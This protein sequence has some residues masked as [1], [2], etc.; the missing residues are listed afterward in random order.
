ML[1]ADSMVMP[2]ARWSRQVESYFR[3]PAA[4]SRD[5]YGEALARI[6]KEH[7]V[8]CVIPTCEEVF[9]LSMCKHLLPQECMVFAEDISKLRELH[10]KYLFQASATGCGIGLPRTML[11][12]SR[13]LLADSWERDMVDCDVVYKRC[14]SR[15]AEGT[16][17]KPRL[18]QVDRLKPSES[19]PWVAQEFIPGEEVC[20]YAVAVDGR[21]T[22][23]ATYKPLHRAGKGAGICFE[24]VASSEIDAF[25]TRFVEKHACSG[26]ISFDFIVSPDRGTFVIECNPRATSGVHL[27][28]RDTD[29]NGIFEG[30]LDSIVRPG[31]G[32]AMV[33]LA[34]VAYGLFS[35]D[36]SMLTDFVSSRDVV[37]KYDDPL[38]VIG[39]MFATGETLFRAARKGI[40]PI[41]A[42]TADIEW[43]GP[44]A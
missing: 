11:I 41:A 43:N 22:A 16:L 19:D 4:N 31:E 32:K 20:C 7:G 3:L 44:L 38:P 29:W 17:V 28:P 9:H 37:L 30:S 25:V 21:L 27:L 24:P 6:V 13:R 23:I 40:S 5:A 35:S 12:R 39:Q 14:Y 2:L 15:F 1:A 36:E 34:M 8:D 26:Q 18:K 42:T 10:D 33:G